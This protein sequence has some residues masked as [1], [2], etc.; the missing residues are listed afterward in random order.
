MNQ[1]TTDSLRDAI[2]SA[3]DTSDPQDAAP[4]AAPSEPVTSTESQLELQTE[5]NDEPETGANADLNALAESRPRDDQGKFKKAEKPEAA[6]QTEMTPGPK[7]GPKTQ[8]D[9]APASWRPEIRE[10]WAKLPQ[11]V[12]SEVARREQ[13]VQRT[14]QETAEARKT[15][16]SY[17]KAFAPY[18]A[19]IRAE[20]ATPIQAI[21]NLMATA[22]KLRTGTGPELA[23]LVA[24][25]VKQFGVGR[26]GQNF[27]E[28]LDAALV[29]Q[30][31]QVDQQQM[32]LQQALQQQL[33]PVQ[34]FMSQFQQMQAV[35]Q[36]QLAQN[37]AGEVE[38]FL[39]KAEFGQDVREEMADLMEVAA[40]RGRELSLQDA[41]RQACMANPR[42]RSVLQQRA[43][44]QSAQ[45]GNAAV[46]RA[47][48][49][50]VSVS[51]APALAAPNGAAPDSVRS[52]IEQAIALSAR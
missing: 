21:D 23:Q 47:R 6:Q 42:V 45:Q 17:A 49:A 33:A 48:S 1:P 43:K 39:G 37:A 52:A 9:R 20:N 32:Q 11:D 51:G 44:A 27:I 46:Q 14:L 7:S 18:E 12:R 31:P 15:L 30:V 26:F 28:Q 25:M 2:A 8:Q 3:I 4:A 29:G 35:Q 34:Q 36:Q 24:G 22:V 5:V 50:A 41:Y 40:R 16:E 38:T 10:H 19:Y 13:E